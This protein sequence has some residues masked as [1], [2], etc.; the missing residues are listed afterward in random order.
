M[1]ASTRPA[2][3]SVALREEAVEAHPEA[4]EVAA[5]GL[6]HQLLAPGGEEVE[7][8]GRG[9]AR[10]VGVAVADL[11]PHRLGDGHD[12]VAGVA[13]LGHRGRAAGQLAVARRH[14]GPEQP[15]LAAEVVDVVLARDAV[16]RELQDP[17]QRVAVGRLAR[18]AHVGRARR[19]GRHELEQDVLRHGRAAAP[20]GLPGAHDRAH[21]AG[22]PTGGQGHV[23]EPRPGDL[24][25]RQPV[26]GR[27]VPAQSLRDR[28]GDLARRA[29]CRLG[30]RH[31]DRARDVALVALGRRRERDGRRRGPGHGVGRGGEGVADRREER[32]V[33]HGRAA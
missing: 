12:V 4:L 25:R 32:G 5:D 27:R 16:P 26:R 7:R 22:E 6:E 21:G 14:R 20:A 3:C 29:A 18:V 8:L 1:P 19:V 9:V 15:H 24:D 31:R 10:L 23:E 17:P 28:L 30:K 11:L 33:A 13:V 2:S